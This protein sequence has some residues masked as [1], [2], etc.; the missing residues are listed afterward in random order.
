MFA[1]L[2]Y[3][4]I[5]DGQPSARPMDPIDREYVLDRRLFEQH[6]SYLGSRPN[7]AVRVVISFDD[8]DES[9]YSLAAP[10]LERHGLRGEFFIVT[11]GELWL[12]D[13]RTGPA[14]IIYI[15]RHT[16]Y[17][18]RAGPDGARYFRVVVP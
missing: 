6:V 18:V 17:S 11:H 15:P 2:L 10:V 3:H 1:V 16:D 7:P 4:G 13:V 9:G 5:E 14:G 12:A 8:G